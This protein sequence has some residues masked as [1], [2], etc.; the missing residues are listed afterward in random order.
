MRS[1]D[2]INEGP[3][4]EEEPAATLAS[5]PELAAQWVAEEN[6]RPA[7][8]V[9]LDEDIEAWWNCGRRETYTPTERDGEV[10]EVRHR[11]RARL[12]LRL[13]DP[14]CPYCVVLDG[15]A[16]S[17]GEADQHV[18]FE[19]AEGREEKIHRA[20]FAERM[21]NAHLA[22]ETDWASV[23]RHHLADLMEDADHTV[24]HT[25]GAPETRK[26]RQ[27]R[28]R[29]SLEERFKAEVR[30]QRRLEKDWKRERT[31][32]ASLEAV[33]TPDVPAVQKRRPSSSAF[34]RLSVELLTA[35]QLVRDLA[36]SLKKLGYARDKAERKA[37]RRAKRRM[38]KWRKAA[39]TPE[40]SKRRNAV[41]A[42]R[43]EDR[44]Q[45][46]VDSGGANSNTL[47]GQQCL[48][49]LLEEGVRTGVKLSSG[50]SSA[51]EEAWR[52]EVQELVLDV[53]GLKGNKNPFKPPATLEVRKKRWEQRFRKLVGK[54]E[55]RRALEMRETLSPRPSAGAARDPV[56]GA[57][58]SA[59]PLLPS[60]VGHR[61]DF[62]TEFC[63][64]R[65]TARWAIASGLAHVLDD[66]AFDADLLILAYADLVRGWS[67]KE[68]VLSP[69]SERTKTVLRFFDSEVWWRLSPGT[70]PRER[71][72]ALLERL[73]GRAKVPTDGL[74]ARFQAA[75]DLHRK[76]L[77]QHYGVLWDEPRASASSDSLDDGS[78]KALTDWDEVADLWEAVVRPGD[79]EDKKR[80]ED[81]RYARRKLFAHPGFEK[82]VRQE[83]VGPRLPVDLQDWIADAL[84]TSS[85]PLRPVDRLERR[86]TKALRDEHASPLECATRAAL[87]QQLTKAYPSLRVPDHRLHQGDLQPRPRRRSE[88]AT[89][90]SLEERQEARQAEPQRAARQAEA[91][92]R[93]SDALRAAWEWR[94]KPGSLEAVESGIERW[95][96]QAISAGPTDRLPDDDARLATL[97]ALH[98]VSAAAAWAR[99]SDLVNPVFDQWVHN[100]VST[101][102]DEARGRRVAEW[103]LDHCEF[104]PAD[105]M[106]GVWRA[107]VN[108][109]SSPLGRDVNRLMVTHG[110]PV[111]FRPQALVFRASTTNLPVWTDTLLEGLEVEHYPD[112]A[113]I[114]RL[115]AAEAREGWQA[116]EDGGAWRQLQPGEVLEVPVGEV[117][118]TIV[119]LGEEPDATEA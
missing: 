72:M 106:Q 91:N 104:D 57:V 45:R 30:R 67:K 52:E 44:L 1:G 9:G 31:R 114:V 5:R 112:G 111:C 33:G 35:C 19:P 27:K 6:G 78:V 65:E 82:W 77:D 39:P 8:A 14:R 61:D 101:W 79:L 87:L 47:E 89:G 24:R 88:V 25:S 105:R 55:R 15:L 68:E 41:R 74:D 49:W 7:D 20:K 117:T 102:Q 83:A 21:V 38:K 48:E 85:R 51:L 116:D 70:L 108:P 110:Q 63:V 69:G 3:T 103:M 71:R 4:E 53:L 73:A 28:M 54:R 97:L 118:V 26:D 100:G 29:A 12:A 115:S 90:A 59:E 37:V 13:E 86:L 93:F 16:Q 98:E 18:V 80:S 11:W 62:R 10:T 66:E 119:G 107:L 95:V 46:F 96:E 58:D 50:R 34:R 76:A 99:A 109:T 56:P 32:L 94:N 75:L 64:R 60:L 17:F 23:D 36:Q 84:A 113:V 92:P 81:R 40:S 22:L 43:K 2:M 42:R